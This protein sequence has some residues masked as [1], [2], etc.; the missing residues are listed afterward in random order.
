MVA[1]RIK[2]ALVLFHLIL[3]YPAFGQ[4]QIIDLNKPV[5]LKPG[6]YRLDSILHFVS[7]QTGAVFSFNSKK[8][9]T[10]Q[11]IN[12][13]NG[14]VSLAKLL[15]LLRDEKGISAKVIEN[16][17]VIS[18]LDVKKEEKKHF[19]NTTVSQKKV[20]PGEMKRPQI[21]IPKTNKEKTPD[22]QEDSV[23]IKS[24]VNPLSKQEQQTQSSTTIADSTK[25]KND[26]T[27]PLLPIAKQ[28][29]MP[30]DSTKRFTSKENYTEKNDTKKERKISRP[31]PPVNKASFFLKSGITVD[32]SLYTGILA[33]AGIPLLYGTISANTNF[34][35]SQVRYGIGS[36][37]KINNEL[38]LHFN[39]NLG[40]LE[41]SGKFSD[42][43][44]VKSP[45]AVKSQLTRFMIAAEFS[46]NRKLRI[47][48]GP[49]FNHL[50][51][52]YF[53]NSVPSDLHAFKENGD[54]L[55]YTINPPYV[56]TNTYSPKSNSNLKTWVGLQVSILYFLKI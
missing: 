25:A 33:Q 38:Q 16:Y 17:I 46:P 28:S 37:F 3:A 48:I 12:L 34:C 55:F 18:S 44:K 31:K 29:F 7:Q 14:R 11:H 6:L 50:K 54:H 39:F 8:L 26:Q 23:I 36:S 52:N 41:K 47:Q 43:T 24:G 51:T 32:E 45:I 1:Y 15:S 35:V 13:K 30:D 56:I 19:I 53:I 5:Q 49:V 4:N 9:N 42:S 2:Q 20:E 27:Q 40:D 22:Q 21:Q 10:K